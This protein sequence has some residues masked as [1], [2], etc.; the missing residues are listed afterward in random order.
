MGNNYFWTLDYKLA[1]QY[2]N[3]ALNSKTNKFRKACTKNNI[4]SVYMEMHNYKKAIQILLPLTLEKDVINDP[5]MFSIILDNLGYSYFKVDNSKGIDYMN[6]VLKIRLQEKND[7]G[8]I[9]SYGRLSEY[10]KKTNPK[11][12]FNYALLGYEKSTKIND[13]ND[14]LICLALLIEKSSGNQLK[15]Y[16]LDYIRINDSLVKA[17]QKAKNQLLNFMT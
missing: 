17:R 7:F 14:R 3:L 16:S 12:A 6:E 9:T 8:L 4:A 5:D 2:Y 11:K 10:Y 15:K 13:I 1:L